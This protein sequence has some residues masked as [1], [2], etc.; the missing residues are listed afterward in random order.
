MSSTAVITGCSSGV[1]LNL[2]ILLIKNNYHV[3]ATIRK[4][5]D[6]EKIINEM[7]KEK[8][9]TKMVTFI[10]MDVS[11]DISVTSGFQEIFSKTEFVDVL[12]CNAG[13]AVFGLCEFIKMEK[14]HDQFETNFFGVIRCLKQVLPKMRQKKKGRIQVISSIAGLNGQSFNDIYCASKF[15][16]EGLFESMAPV[17]SSLGIHLSIIEPGVILTNFAET[18][19]KTYGE[20]SEKMD[21]ELD[22]M[23]SKY[24]SVTQEKFKDPTL[25]QTGMEVAEVCLKAIT[26]ENPSLRYLTN[27]H[28]LYLESIKMKYADFTGNKNLKASKKN[29][30]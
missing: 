8:I 27:H 3:F 24:M 20:S 4:K 29:L 16:V 25:A 2:V 14:I 12:I 10:V 23:L 9:E 21:Q 17:Y 26:D 28:P 11:S 5:E 15:A 6:S 30:E 13:F 22:A 1:G 18:A 7:E 19:L